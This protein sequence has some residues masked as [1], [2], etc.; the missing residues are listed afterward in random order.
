MKAERAKLARLQRLEKLRAIAKQN[1]VTEAARAET[2][3]TQL[4]TLAERTRSLTQEYAAR[5]D[6]ADGAD[7]ARMARLSWGCKAL[8]PPPMPTGNAPMRWPTGVRPNW[9]PPSAAAP[10]WRKERRNRRVLSPTSCAMPAFP[11]ILQRVS[12][13]GT[14]LARTMHNS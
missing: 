2:T 14:I 3:L 6:M 13:V 5:R 8:P 9:S 11:A 12:Q 10:R 4:N 1:A 7:L